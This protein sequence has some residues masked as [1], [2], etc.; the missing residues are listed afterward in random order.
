MR[1]SSLDFHLSAIKNNDNHA[2]SRNS[3][4]HRYLVVK[5]MIDAYFGAGLLVDPKH[6][7]VE[8]RPVAVVVVVPVRNEEVGVDHFM[9]QGLDQILPRPQLKQRNT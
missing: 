6:V 2:T 3:H 7:L 8:G 9:Q 1:V 4:F 5:V